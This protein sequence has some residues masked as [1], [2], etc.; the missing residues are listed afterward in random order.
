MTDV[1]L[2]FSPLDIENKQLSFVH[3]IEKFTDTLQAIKTH[4]PEFILSPGDL[5]EHSNEDFFSAYMGVLKSLNTTDVNI[6]V[7]NTPG[8]HDRRGESH[9]TNVGLET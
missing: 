9:V 3:S 8:N 4:N 6:P 2:G 1:H 7:Y 5:V